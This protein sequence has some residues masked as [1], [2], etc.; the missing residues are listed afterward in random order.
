V[1]PSAPFD[2]VIVLVMENREYSEVI[3]SSHAPYVNGLATR[4]TLATQYYAASHPSVPNYL[5][6]IGGSTFGISSDCTSCSVAGR[7]LVDQLQA[8]G[9]SW[10]AYMQGM[11]SACYQGAFSGRY[12]KKHDPFLYFDDVRQNSAR[13]HLVVPFSQLGQDIASGGL[14]RF[15]WITPDLCND[16]H[17]CSTATADAFL[18]HQV[19]AL[20]QQLGSNGVLFLTWDEGASDRGCCRYA[21]GG[22]VVTIVAGP[23]ARLHAR[24]G[25][26][27]D[28]YSLL[29]AIEDGWGLPRLG[30][31]ACVCTHSLALLRR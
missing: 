2:R 20:L 4:F 6:L 5:A 18:K 17:D 27:L 12:A 30:H 19:P 9:I 24:S 3:G 25:V 15:V 31:A 1:S 8:H 29:R 26:S 21:G 10:K 23:G 11:P 22:H 14:P 28:H 13:C 7:N 16:G